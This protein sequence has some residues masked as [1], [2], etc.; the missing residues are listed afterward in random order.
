MS[1]AI[2]FDRSEG[3]FV[4]VDLGALRAPVSS[5]FEWVVLVEDGCGCWGENWLKIATAIQGELELMLGLKWDF[6]DD[7]FEFEDILSIFDSSNRV[8]NYFKLIAKLSRKKR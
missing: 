3:D 6:C 5:S 4:C 7:W 8:F 2:R 1:Q